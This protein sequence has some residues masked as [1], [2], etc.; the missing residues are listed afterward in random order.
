MADAVASNVI[1]NT[2][3]EYVIHLTNL[4]DGTGESA[5]TKVDKST[6]VAVGGAEPASLDLEYVDYSIQGFASVKLLWDHSTD[7]LMTVLSGN[8]FKDFRGRHGALRDLSRTSG[9]PDPRSSGGTGDV[10]LT[11][12]SGATTGTYDIT[13]WFHKAV[14]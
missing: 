5:V 2:P 12:P 10:L 11:A 8:G 6:L 3:K 13:L 4:S 14:V 9:L 1:L 7:D